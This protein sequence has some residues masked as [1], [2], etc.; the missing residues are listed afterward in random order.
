MKSLATCVAAL[1]FATQNYGSSY[2][3]AEP[4]YQT[5]PIS[6]LNW[7]TDYQAALKQGAQENKTILLFFTG[8]DWCTW[9]RKRLSI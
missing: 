6:S 3:M 2:L 9:I 5:A 1:L 8:S 7:T 4:S